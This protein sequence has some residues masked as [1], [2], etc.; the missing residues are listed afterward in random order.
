MIILFAYV[1]CK[2]HSFN[3]G[4]QTH[5]FELIKGKIILAGPDLIR[6]GLYKKSRGPPEVREILLLALKKS[7]VIFWENCEGIIRQEPEEVLRNWEWSLT[8]SQQENRD[9]SPISTR[10]WILPT[11]TWVWKKSLSS[12][13]EGSLEDTLMWYSVITQPCDTLRTGPH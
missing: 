11:Y 6:R 1:I 7:V 2:K 12:R 3:Y 13:K 10:N 9:P 8:D 4:P 5:D